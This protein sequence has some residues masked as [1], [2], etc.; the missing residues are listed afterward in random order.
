VVF[1]ADDTGFT[2]VKTNTA[3]ALGD[4]NPAAGLLSAGMYT[5]TLRSFHSGSSG[6][7]DLLGNPLDGTGEGGGGD[8]VTTFS[9]AA[10]PVAVGIP[11]F[12]RGPSD[13]DAI[14]LPAL[15]NG[16]TFALSYTN[17]NV[18]PATGAATVTFSSS[19]AVLRNNIQ[20]AL[21]QLT[22]IGTDNGVPNAVAVVTNDLSGGANVLVTFQNSLATATSQLLTSTKPGVTIGQAYINVANNMPDCSIPVALSNGQ[23]ATSGS[24]TLEYNPALLTISGA[25]TD[26]AGA[27]FTVGTTI[28][29]ATSA[30]AVLSFSSPTSISA[31][32]KPITIGCL[33]ATVPLTATASYG[34]KQLLHFSSEQLNGAAGPIAITNQD[35]LQ[36]VAYFGDVTGTGGPFNLSD[37]TAISAVAAMLPSTTAQT[38]PGFGSFPNLDPV[39]IGDVALQNLGFVNS[40]DASTLNQELVLPRTTIPFAPIGLSIAPTGP[41][42]TL[43]V[44]AGTW[45]PDGATLAIP[46][47]IDTARPV[48]STG[49][50]DASLAFSF[51]PNVFA[52]SPSDVQFGTVPQTANGWQLKAEVNNQT[53]LIGIELYSSNPIQSVAGGS[54]VIV[55]MHSRSEPQMVTESQVLASTA[56]LRLVS[57]VDPSGGPRVYQTQVS[58]AHGAFVL[59]VVNN[60]APQES[61]VAASSTPVVVADLAVD[62]SRPASVI[63]P[64]T[65][66]LPVAIVEQIFSDLQMTVRDLHL[67]WL[68][69]PLTQAALDNEL[70][71]FVRATWL[72]LPPAKDGQGGSDASQSTDGNDTS[73][74][75]F[76][77]FQ[78]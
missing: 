20:T 77:L 40:T 13:T 23:G 10:P 74:F 57:F 16:A 53:G 4:F 29:S 51:D 42:P 38:L 11:D 58:D 15:G 67:P 55:S 2:F 65:S 5:V 56:P 45:A 48:G 62:E 63:E 43:S 46:I 47:N 54:L 14:S 68:Q 6:F 35:G 60:S 75:V 12:A 78:F 7:Q 8:F 25:T 71:D 1:N 34:A 59:D 18:N 32:A 76:A 61:T 50:T 33:L 70:D 27:I 64:L 26:I 28:N 21:N 30:T 44:A 9:I 39:I 17:P 3:S 52:V 49:M 37:V 41:D 69:E 36:V 73:L 31:T 72:S 24:F 19:S 66:P 22:Q